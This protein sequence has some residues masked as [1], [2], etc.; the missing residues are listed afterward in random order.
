MAKLLIIID[1]N[2]CIAAIPSDKLV[3]VYRIEELAVIIMNK[4]S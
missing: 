3:W 1:I 2:T 4:P